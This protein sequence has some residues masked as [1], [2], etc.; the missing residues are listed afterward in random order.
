MAACEG[1][2]KPRRMGEG[3]FGKLAGVVKVCMF[4]SCQEDQNE[5]HDQ[6]CLT[7]PSGEVAPA[8]FGFAGS[9]P[10]S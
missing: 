8:R 5:S 7:E 4:S 3:A 6:S 2:K 9:A 1:T 10:D